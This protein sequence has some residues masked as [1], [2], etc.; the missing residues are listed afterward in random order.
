MKDMCKSAGVEG[1]KTNHSLRS[2]GVS[3]L[4]HKGVQ[5]KLI[6]E[7]SGHRSL[8]ALRVYERPTDEQLVAASRVLAPPQS[9]EEASAPPV[10]PRQQ[11]SENLS[12]PQIFSTCSF[13]NC[14]IQV[15][16][17]PPTTTSIYE[18]FK[19]I[20]IAELEDF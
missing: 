6:Q 20:N 12:F 13:S 5:E 7:R 11:T 16:L 17:A 2:C 18:E 1:K 3:S 4:Y 9:R 10:R 15:Q 14:S 19:G 8:A